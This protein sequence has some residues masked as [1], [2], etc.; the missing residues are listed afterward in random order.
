M[1]SDL[2]DDLSMEAPSPSRRLDMERV[3]ERGLL[4]RRRKHALVAAVGVASVVVLVAGGIG[5]TRLDRSDRRP[6]VAATES[7]EARTPEDPEQQLARL[8]DELYSQL[9]ELRSVL[10]STTAQRDELLGRL[11][12]LRESGESEK[13]RALERELEDLDER[14]ADIADE[15]DQ[16]QERIAAVTARIIGDRRFGSS[17]GWIN[18]SPEGP[19][20]TGGY[21]FSDLELRTGPQ[22]DPAE[23]S[24]RVIL[25]GRIGFVD[26]YPG[27]RLCT[28]TVFDRRGD[29]IGA[30]TSEFSAAGESLGTIK[31]R[32]D[33][34]GTPH[35][36]DIECSNERLD[37]PNGRFSFS[38]IQVTRA[39]TQWPEFEVSFRYRWQ[40]RGE[41]SFQ[42]CEIT[43]Y[44]GDDVVLEKVMQDFSTSGR[45]G[46]SS[47]RIVRA[48]G[49]PARATI[50]CTPL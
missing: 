40:G 46:R 48:S 2:R 10:T 9:R 23:E 24:T 43:V 22:A 39:P 3:W 11:D 25:R 20:T 19:I 14:I 31:D 13:A 5:L 16:T 4:L 41:P 34:D 45:Q 32:I 8:R 26:G 33:V 50:S 38:N 27:V 12:S 15:I 28:W 18:A 49:D 47:F 37:N 17:G 7:P 30:A 36:V 1:P 21:V 42:N 35:R 6:P 44:D 29:E